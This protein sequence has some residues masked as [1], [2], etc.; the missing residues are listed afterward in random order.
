MKSTTE[1]LLEKGMDLAGNQIVTDLRVGLGYTA[2]EVSYKDVGLAYT[3]SRDVSRRCT[4]GKETGEITGR[5]AKE[6]FGWLRKGD[7]LSTAIG[8]ATLNALLQ[9]YLPE[10]LGKDF[11]QFLKIG[12]KDRVGMVGFF[13][14]L[15]QPIRRRCGELLV[16]EREVNKGKGLLSPE[17]IRSHIPDCSIV[18]LTA[19]TLINQTFDQITR[20]IG[21]AREVVLVG[22]STPLLPDIF[23]ETPIT[24]LAGI[25]MIDGKKSLQIVSEGGGTP[26]LTSSGSVKK[27]VVASKS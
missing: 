12:P 15:I 27:I 17:D 20:H 6:L 8:L 10:S 7:L 22:P 2:V 14:P 9:A 3:F 5:S 25:Q 4:V 24:Y 26:R 1:R 18:I 13:P 21:G 23:E 16:F 11:L 19:T